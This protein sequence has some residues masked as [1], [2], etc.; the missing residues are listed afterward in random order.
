MAH[1]T[2][3]NSTDCKHA[4]PHQNQLLHKQFCCTYILICLH[5]TKS[6]SFIM[7]Y[8]ILPWTWDVTRCFWPHKVHILVQHNKPKKSNPPFTYIQN[9]EPT[10]KALP[11]FVTRKAHTTWHSKDCVGLEAIMS[12]RMEKKEENGSRVRV[13]EDNKTR[14]L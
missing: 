10:L 13:A 3:F 8:I 2:L 6:L 9:A 1:Q 14:A 12:E 5:R 4:A 11:F 7:I